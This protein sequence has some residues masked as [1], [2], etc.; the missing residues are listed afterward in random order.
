MMQIYLLDW[1]NLALKLLHVIAGIAWIGASFYF[2]WLENKLDRLNNRDEIAGNLWAV[3]GGGFYHLVKYLVAPS[4]LPSELTW[5]K[6]EAYAT[7]VSG[8]ALLALI[9]YAGAELYMIDIIKYDFEKY[10]AVIISILGI[11]FGWLVYDMMCRISLK[12]NVYTLILSI[13]I[14]ITIMSWIYSELFSYRGAFMQ[15]GTVLGTIMVANVL[16]VIIPGQKKVVASLINNETPD[17]KYGMVAK[18]RSLHNNYLTLPVIF[19]MISNHYPIIYATKYSWLIIPIILIIGA[20]IRHFFNVKHTGI[21]P[22]YWI[23]FPIIILLSL[24]MFISNLGKPKLTKTNQNAHIIKIIPEPI[25][26]NAQEIIISKCSMCHAKEPLWDNMHSAPKQVMLETT[27]DI[28]MNIQNIYSQSVA[29]FAM[30][31]GNVSFLE[32]HER[33]QIEEL[34]LTILNLTKNK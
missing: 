28:L 29:S 12:T 9:Y 18:Q 30:P 11:I 22:P 31:P 13:F 26:T 23:I 20:L 8:F 21:K 1:L 33:A 4:K 27:E 6:W 7:W 2:N 17:A 24:S 25:L 10:E 19:I 5:F 3:H 14:L 16:M 15:I 32:N 34:Y